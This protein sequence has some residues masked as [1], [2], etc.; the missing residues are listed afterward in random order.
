MVFSP[1]AP[2]SRRARPRSEDRA[3]IPVV[4]LRLY[5]VMNMMLSGADYDPLD[6]GRE[7]HRNMRFPQLIERQDL[8]DHHQVDAEDRDLGNV[9]TGKIGEASEGHA[10]EKVPAIT[11]MA[12]S[13]IGW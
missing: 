3:E 9:G 6:C 8:G 2:T 5:A 10:G 12:I 7:P 1:M 4:V 13:S 11:F